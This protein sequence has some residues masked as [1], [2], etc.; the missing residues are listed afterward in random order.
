MVAVAA[1]DPVY[2]VVRL[3]SASPTVTGCDEATGALAATGVDATTGALAAFAA[4][5]EF[6][7]VPPPSPP[8]PHP[9]TTNIEITP[10]A[11]KPREF[12]F[13]SPPEL[14]CIFGN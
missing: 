5:P 4:P 13:N 10:A 8:P 6:A 2:G 12:V 9:A 11:N 7:G 14:R 3:G 1:V